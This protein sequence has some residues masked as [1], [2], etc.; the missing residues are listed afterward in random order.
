MDA[1]DG[2]A[3]LVTDIQV[4]P[5]HD[6]C[7][8]QAWV[9]SETD[10]DDAAWFEPFDLWYRFPAWCAPYL[11]AENGDPFLAALLLP[12]MRTGERLAIS[13]ALSPRL[14]D[15]LPEIQSIYAAFDSRAARVAVEAVPR[16]ELRV[17]ENGGSWV[18]LFF[19]MG[20]DS[21]YSLL[22]NE[23]EHPADEKTVTHLLAI[24]GFDIVHG[25]WDSAFAPHLLSN[26]NRVA[27][28]KEKILLP[29]ITNVRRVGA[30]LARWT[31]MHGGV[32][33]SVALALG[34]AFRR[35]TIAASARYDK[36]Y[37]WGTHPVLDP[38]WSTDRTMVIHD[39]CERDVIQK[40]EI[41]AQSPLVMETLRVC[42]W[43]GRGYNCGRCLKCLRTAIDL[44]QAGYLDRCATL[45]HEI[46]PAE[47]QRELRMGS[48]PVHTAAFRQRLETFEATGT[49][50]ELRDVLMDY[51]AS[52]TE[53]QRR[54][55]P[56]PRRLM[57]RLQGRAFWRD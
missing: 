26:F 55:D 30:N 23:R 19:S 2:G 9:E 13:A 16:R 37:P 49:H 51:L 45:P 15:A 48:G 41:I 33:A 40:T 35:V 47:L 18:G 52:P 22:E 8:L 38:L 6:H 4:I 12:A 31:M 34:A 44:M 29:V 3:M 11:C 39:G 36:I 25:E 28:E 54:A 42:P 53:T 1:D 21:F 17:A 14:L 46:D 20:V 56:L 10:P 7:R 5:A 57:D 50:P 27:T 24:H 43:E 32:L